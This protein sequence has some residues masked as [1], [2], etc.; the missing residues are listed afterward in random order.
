MTAAVDW[1]AIEGEYLAGKKSVRAIAAEY[2]V[3]DKAIRNH[4]KSGGWSRD[5]AGQLR[6]KVKAHF[7][8]SPQS[9]PQSSP[10]CEVRTFEES[11][12]RAIDLNE[13]A[14]GNAEMV[15]RRIRAA[16][17][18]E[19]RVIP[20]AD[21]KRLSEANAMNLATVRTVLTLDDPQQQPII[22]EVP[23]RGYEP[24]G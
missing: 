11:S 10:Q 13:L 5:P 6:E 1:L 14:L 18:D 15:L 23:E 21:L 19:E 12:R 8:G 4:A 16:L 22:L 9:S 24:L 17:S 7:A 3:S 2:G 20:S